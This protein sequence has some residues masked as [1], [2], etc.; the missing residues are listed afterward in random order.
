MEPAVLIKKIP[1]KTLSGVEKSMDLPVVDL[2]AGTLLFRGIRLP[3]ISKGDDT[4]LFIRDFLGDPVGDSFCMTPVHNV[5]FY[6]FPYIPFGA[7]TVGKRFNA[8]N[9]YVTRKTLRVVCL[10]SPSPMIRGGN[11][12]QLDGTAPIQRCDKFNYEC[13]GPIKEDDLTEK[14]R[15]GE[16]TVEEAEVLQEKR[17]QEVKSWDNCIHPM[18]PDL[19]GWMAIAD[20]D[21]LDSFDEKMIVT[22]DTSLSKYLLELNQRRPGKL[23]EILSYMYSDKRRH[24]GIPEIVIHPWLKKNA[25]TVMT[26]AANEEEVIEQIQS[27]SDNFAFLPCASIT[28]AGILDGINGNFQ[29]S[30]L[31]DGSMKNADNTVRAAIEGNLESFMTKIQ[32][33]GL[34]I[35]DLGMTKARFDSRT[36]FYVLD[37]FAGRETLKGQGPYS[38]LLFPLE[39]PQQTSFASKYR[40]LFRSYFP[41]KFLKQEIIIP[42]TSPVRRA[43]IFERPAIFKKMFDN[44]GKPGVFPAE[45]HATVRNSAALFQRN[46]MTRKTRGG[47]K[48]MTRRIIPPSETPRVIVET[49]FEEL[50]HSSQRFLTKTMKGVYSAFWSRS[51]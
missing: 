42:K 13:K 14:V 43:F 30:E 27:L 16:I 48:N 39:T 49:V 12:K 8:I 41:D 24:R 2:P 4:R 10:I 20:L 37:T 26:D 5:F 18:Y 28:S 44:I 15:R 3:D 17:Q 35:P 21:A 36:G 1:Y 22:K 45:H 51:R 40:V 19:N 47:S 31:P 23:A 29:A 25:D 46:S 9:V 6:P 33:T 7:H 38:Q 11:I 34:D 32:T 50:S